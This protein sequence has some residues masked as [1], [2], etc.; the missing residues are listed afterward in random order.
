MTIL[1]GDIKLFPSLTNGIPLGPADIEVVPGANDVTRDT[2]LETALLI[3]IFTDCRADLGDPLPFDA[4]GRGGWFGESVLGEKFGSKLWLLRRSNLTNET[5]TRAKEYI[6]DALDRHIISEGIA[7]EYEVTV[8]KVNN[9][10]KL[11][12]SITALDDLTPLY[13]YYINWQSQIGRI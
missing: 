5:L 7:K 13:E 4:D 2:G 10:M 1:G 3:A 12:I 11:S 8:S 9:R 6:E